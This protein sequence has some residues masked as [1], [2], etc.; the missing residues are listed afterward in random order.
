MRFD[1]RKN[2][3]L[4]KIKIVPGYIENAY[5]SVLIE[6]GRTRVI[7]TASVEDKVP[8]WL[9]G[10]K[11]GWVSAEYSMIPGATDSRYQREVNKG[12]LSGRTQEIQRLIGRSLRAVTDL[13]KIPDI[14]IWIDCDVIQAD[15]G[16]RTASITGGFLALK[17]ACQ[18]LL[19]EGRITEDPINEHLAAVSAGVVNNNVVLDLPYAED[20][21][22]QVDLNLVMTESG[23]FV[24]VQGTG[25]ENTFTR[26]ELNL[27]LEYGEKGI[28]ELIEIQKKSL[29][30]IV[31]ASR[32]TGKIKE[33]KSILEPRGYRVLSIADFPEL[34]DIEE[35]GVTFKEN[36]VIKAK[37][38]GEK[39]GL[40][41]LADDSGLEVDVL[42]GNPGIY[43]ARYS[44]EDSTDEKNNEKLIKE[45]EKYS[46][47]ER[48][49][50]Y[51]CALALY[52]PKLNKVDIVEE[53]CE[54][55]ILNEYRG[56]GGF[57]YDP[58]FYLES[59]GK[60]FG[61]I[62][63]EVKNRISHR[64]KALERLKKLLENL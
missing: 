51:V 11:Q 34:E 2:D 27:M 6:F 45:L 15:G 62:P 17:M 64:G 60:T 41:A 37:Y 55:I 56:N 16:T 26:A 44:G 18:G 48:T 49:G 36:S 39:T 29:K 1:G 14:T 8:G 21:S 10:S 57:G 28:S 7:C 9:K 53:T 3:E 42:N 50:R 46:F 35:T 13:K 59:L 43:S 23:K 24:E 5:R 12:K 20:S 33:F 63:L 40:T 58:L 22:A 32:N 61:E 31:I 38:V 25:E 52:D 54:G 47:N 4:R 30:E 19:S